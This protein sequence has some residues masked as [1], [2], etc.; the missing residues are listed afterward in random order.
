[1]RPGIGAGQRP[2]SPRGHH[3]SPRLGPQRPPRPPRREPAGRRVVRADARRPPT[4][5]WAAHN[6]RFHRTGRKKLHHPAVGDLDLNFEAM[7]LPSHPGLTLL[8]YTA[9]KN[10]PTADNLKLLSAWAATTQV[11]S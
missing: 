1:M 10:T 7:E 11:G 2:G 9:P 8:V 5:R 3:R 6:V 4:A